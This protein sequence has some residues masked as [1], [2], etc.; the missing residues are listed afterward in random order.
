MVVATTGMAQYCCAVIHSRLRGERPP[1]PPADI[2]NDPCPIFVTLKYLTGELRGCIGSFAAEPLHEQLK[3]YAIA[4]AFQ[5]SRFRPVALGELHSLSCSVCL[6]HTFEK[7]SS[8]KD[9]QIGTHGIRIRY[10]SYSATYLPSVMPEQG[11]DH[12]QALESLLRKAGYTGQVTETVLN[13]LTLTRYQESKAGTTF[14]SL[15][16]G[17]EHAA[18]T[19]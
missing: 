1:E 16:I 4:S 9:W 6:L 5:D 11:W 3:N 17:L 2:P 10:K 18:P 15:N 13:D 19:T 12:F 7:A 14:A 8:W